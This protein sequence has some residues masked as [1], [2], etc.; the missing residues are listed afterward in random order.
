MEFRKTPT[1][2][3]ILSLLREGQVELPPLSL[4]VE[5]V[6]PRTESG[7]A[8]ALLT[9]DW[10]GRRYQFAVECDRL[11]SPKALSELVA[12]ARR[13]ARVPERYPMVLVP[14]LPDARLAELQAAGVSG[15][16]LCGNGVVVVPK[17]VLVYRTGRPNQFRSEAE[18]K[19][20]FRG[21][22]SLVPRLFLVEP[23]FASVQD[24]RRE[25]ERRGGSVALATVSKVCKSLESLLVIERRREKGSAARK[26]R[27]L[28]PEKLLELLA[29]NYVPPAV[30]KTVRGKW[31]LPPEA[32]QERLEGAKLRGTRVVRTGFGSVGSYAVMAKEPVEY[33]YTSDLDATLKALG[34]AFEPTERFPNLAFSETA[35]DTVYFDRR[36]GL[37]APPVQAY[38]ELLDG[39]KRSRETAEQLR[40]A[41]LEPLSAAATQKE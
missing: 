15:I 24:A 39:D 29:K 10:E 14:Y 37:T 41:I 7:V 11:W 38:L 13:Y 25:V 17:E 2:S 32:L 5:E 34:D 27:L 35:D 19:N 26:L 36:P 33:F 22:S 16:D 12:Q 6:N 23:D 31:S 9:L 20:V 30:T 4:S 1:E 3:E 18:I 28:Q 21:N 40:R 8:D